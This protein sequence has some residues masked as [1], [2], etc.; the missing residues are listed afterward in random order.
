MPA[1][2][3]ALIASGSVSSLAGA[4]WTWFK[5]RRKVRNRVT[6]RLQDGKEISIRTDE[7]TP[8]EIEAVIVKLVE[9]EA[10]KTEPHTD[11]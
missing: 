5:S 8:Q 11:A 4:L 3:L 7:A 9:A 1:I 10:E 2:I 6:I